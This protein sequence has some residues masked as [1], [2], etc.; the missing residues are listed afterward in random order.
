MRH[1]GVEY[2]VVQGIERGV[3]KWSV[4]V[5]GTIVAGNEQ[6]RPAAVIAAEEA[7]DR[8]IIAKLRTLP[9]MT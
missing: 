7:I 2:T 8:A 5:E 3:W 4:Y 1:R 6:T 9:P